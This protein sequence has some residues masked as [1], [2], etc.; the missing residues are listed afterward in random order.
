MKT[1][2]DLSELGVG[3]VKDTSYDN[4]YETVYTQTPEFKL[5]QAELEVY[6]A[7]PIDSMLIA[8]IA[9]AVRYAGTNNLPLAVWQLQKSIERINF[10]AG[11]RLDV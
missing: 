8:E 9:D 3:P 10:L 11:K 7:L 6:K 5:R 4:W 1:E 2:T